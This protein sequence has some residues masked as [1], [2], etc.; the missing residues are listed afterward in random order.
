MKLTDL[1]TAGGPPQ[2]A[3]G[4]FPLGNVRLRGV[5]KSLETIFYSRWLARHVHTKGCHEIFKIHQNSSK[6][7][8][9]HQNSTKFI[10][11]YWNPWYPSKSIGSVQCMCLKMS[12]LCNFFVWEKI[13]IF[14][15]GKKILANDRFF[16]VFKYSPGRQPARKFLLCLAVFRC[17]I[18]EVVF[19]MTSEVS[20]TQ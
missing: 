8:K 9:I 10:K 4:V 11:I 18:F 16:Y 6:F 13:I 2:M 15:F 14:K 1:I 3:R 17:H 20:Q 5:W 19:N 7:I 12:T